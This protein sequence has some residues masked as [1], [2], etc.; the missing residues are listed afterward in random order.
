MLIH[1]RRDLLY[2]NIFTINRYLYIIILD[3]NVY[4]IYYIC[5]Y[6]IISYKENIIEIQH[7]FIN[8]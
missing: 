8:Y 2:V 5:Y 1:Q 7:L 4:I 6:N 3:I